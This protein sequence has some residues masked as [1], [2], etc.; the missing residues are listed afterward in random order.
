MLIHLVCVINRLIKRFTD[1]SE[2]SINAELLKIRWLSK[3]GF[4]TVYE[5]LT[6]IMPMSNCVSQSSFI[7]WSNEVSRWNLHHG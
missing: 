6:Q 4:S 2:M 7:H 1:G 5:E 3:I